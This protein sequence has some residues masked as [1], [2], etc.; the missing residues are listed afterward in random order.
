MTLPQRLWYTLAAAWLALQLSSCHDQDVPLG[1]AVPLQLRTTLD[2]TVLHPGDT[3]RIH[4]EILNKQI[5]E[6][7]VRFPSTCQLSFEVRSLDGEVVAP[8]VGLCGAAITYR[9]F[10]PGTESFEFLWA[11]EGQPGQRLSPGAYHVVAG[12][13]HPLKAESP[14]VGLTID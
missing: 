1:P 11:G 6:V 14:A 5:T 12:L 13:G 7:T 2:R 3:V 4:L 10:R 9:A 8:P